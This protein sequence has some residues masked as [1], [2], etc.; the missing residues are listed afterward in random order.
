MKLQEF[1]ER[2]TVN[3]KLHV[4]AGQISGKFARKHGGITSGHIN[5][6]SFFCLQRTKGTLKTINVLQLIN[7]KIMPAFSR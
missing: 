2:E 3:M 4:S 1:G 6:A 5:V 7:K